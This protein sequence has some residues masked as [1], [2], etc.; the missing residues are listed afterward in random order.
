VVAD[1]FDVWMRLLSRIANSILWLQG[2]H[3][4]AVA[5]LRAV[6]ERGASIRDGS[7]WRHAGSEHTTSRATASPTF[8][9]IL[10]SNSLR[11]KPV[12]T[13]TW[14]GLGSRNRRCNS[15]SCV[16]WLTNRESCRWMTALNVKLLLPP[17][18]SRA[19]SV[20]RVGRWPTPPYGSASRGPSNATKR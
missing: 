19:A 15:P 17:R 18:Q 10:G 20:L 7:S 9:R 2:V 12:C 4:P 3:P 16:R 11:P 6:A 14:C 1:V 8:L 13:P 5:N